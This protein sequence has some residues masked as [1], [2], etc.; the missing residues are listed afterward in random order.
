MLDL[1]SVMHRLA[2]TRPVFHS[3]ADFQHALAW[4][5]HVEHRDARIRLEYKLFAGEKVYLDIWCELRD[6]ATALELKYPTRRTSIISKENERFDLAQHGAQDVTRYDIVKDVVRIERVVE[7]VPNAAAAV[8]VLT[9]DPSYWSPSPK[10]AP[11]IDAA[12]RIHEG[13]VLQRSCAWGENAGPGTLKDRTEILDVRGSYAMKWQDYSNSN[14]KWGQFR[15]VI[16]EA[17]PVAP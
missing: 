3:E 2:Q 15:F 17:S 14:D 1:S 6:H 4:Q 11:T 5:L 12:F 7:T 13:R 9:N 8:I 16:I 10:A